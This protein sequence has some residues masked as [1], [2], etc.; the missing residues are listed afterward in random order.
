M[1]TTIL[2]LLKR[3]FRKSPNNPDGVGLSDYLQTE[4]LRYIDRDQVGTVFELGAKDGRD[5]IL[6]ADYFQCR[7]YAFE[8][9]PQALT[10]CRRRL[11]IRKD[12]I[13][14]EKAVWDENCPIPFFPVVHS[15]WQNGEPTEGCPGGANIGASSCFQARSDY[16]QRY[17]QEEI[18]VP[19]IRLDSFCRERSIQSIDLLCIDLQGALLRALQG[20]GDYLGKVKYIVAEIENREIYHEQDLLPEIDDYLKKFGF[21]QAA[22]KYRDAWFMDYLYLREDS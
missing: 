22:K 7:L 9:N 1:K 6:L 2:N 16:L 20:L 19:A 12:I 18:T 10:E 11:E 15:T 17:V 14:V 13:L 3:G 8:C 5:S 4:F 21:R